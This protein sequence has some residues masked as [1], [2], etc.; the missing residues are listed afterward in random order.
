MKVC[1]KCKKEKTV[2]EFGKWAAGKDGLCLY[3]KD[4]VSNERKEYLHKNKEKIHVAR[5]KQ[6]EINPERFK[7][8]AKKTYE[9]HREKRLEK[10]RKYNEQNRQ[11]INERQREYY[12][13]NKDEINTRT[14]EYLA[15][16]QGKRKSN[17]YYHKIKEK[18]D[19]KIKARNNL[20][21]AVRVGKITKPEICEKCFKKRKLHGHHEDYNKPLEVIWVCDRCHTKIHKG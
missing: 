9:K 11:R 5:K 13:K 7:K 21:Y 6:R 3:C 4:C 17:E 8:S 1:N 18:F 19:L 12:S 14:N 16:E 2:N 10:T 20:R 15:T